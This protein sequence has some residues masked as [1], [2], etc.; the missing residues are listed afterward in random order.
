MAD[1][2]AAVG[3]K[4]S[5]YYYGAGGTQPIATQPSA[6][7][8][9][10]SPYYYGGGGLQP[11]PPSA[12]SGTGA[13]LSGGS[14][15]QTNQPWGSDLLAPRSLE[16]LQ[17]LAA[18]QIDASIKGQT[19]PLRSQIDILGGRETNAIQQIGS[20]FSGLQPYV[21]GEADKVQSA[22]ETAFN[23]SQDIFNTA[24]QRMNQLKQDRAADAQAMAQKIA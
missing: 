20:L 22:Y 15:D 12:P 18:A 6:V 21:S 1:Q 16:D 19:D 24:Q 10:D 8:S 3:S 17:K 14:G 9:A 23:A 13:G 4:D 11:Q 2:P 5:P 7:G